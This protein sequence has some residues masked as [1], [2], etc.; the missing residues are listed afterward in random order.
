MRCELLKDFFSI[1][2]EN[3]STFLL[4]GMTSQVSRERERE[5]SR[6]IRPH[7]AHTHLFAT[8]AAATFEDFRLGLQGF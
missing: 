5:M 4:L 3:I 8:A 6:S 1:S 7:V 2:I